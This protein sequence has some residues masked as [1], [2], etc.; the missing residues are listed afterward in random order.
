VEGGAG[1]EEVDGW[2]GGG[3]GKEGRKTKWMVPGRPVVLVQAWGMERE[4][5]WGRRKVDVQP[6][7]RMRRVVGGG[8]DVGDEV[9]DGGGVIV[10]RG[11]VDEV[12]FVGGMVVCSKSLI[13]DPSIT[14]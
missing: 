13:L 11:G 2:M 8:V 7:P 9:G 10:G 14:E 6:A 5:R 4:V 12:V 1:G 3:D